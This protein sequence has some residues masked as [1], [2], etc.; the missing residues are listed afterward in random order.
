LKNEREKCGEIDGAEGTQ[1]NPAG[2]EAVRGAV[3]RVEE[4]A[5]DGRRIPFHRRGTLYRGKPVGKSNW[6]SVAIARALLE[7]W[8]AARRARRRCRPRKALDSSDNDFAPP[9]HTNVAR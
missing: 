9:T 7:E 6:D 4:P 3:S 5:N 2:Q 8:S 1:E